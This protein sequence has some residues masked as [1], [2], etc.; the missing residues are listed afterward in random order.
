MK[1]SSGIRECAFKKDD[2][3][4]YI[5]QSVKSSQTLM[6]VALKNAGISNISDVS[7]F[8]YNYDGGMI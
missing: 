1:K 8:R 7:S 2:V 5:N 3:N 6:T 4:R